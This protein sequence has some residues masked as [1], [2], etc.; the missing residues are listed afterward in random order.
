MTFFIERCMEWDCFSNRGHSSRSP[1]SPLCTSLQNFSRHPFVLL[2]L[3]IFLLFFFFS[4][5]G[6][7][8]PRCSSAQNIIHSLFISPSAFLP[9]F[10]NSLSRISPHRGP[11]LTDKLGT[12][13]I[14]VMLLYPSVAADVV[15]FLYIYICMIFVQ[16]L[17]FSFPHS[18]AFPCC[19]LALSPTACRYFHTSRASLPCC[20]SSDCGEKKKSV[21]CFQQ[22][23]EGGLCRILGI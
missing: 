21:W 3:Y 1:L 18:S 7:R 10:T 4:L 19:F 8:C 20:D 11:N 16:S 14:F 22:W 9:S 13:L 15:F 2:S 17:F 5:L 23:D 12:S 6:T